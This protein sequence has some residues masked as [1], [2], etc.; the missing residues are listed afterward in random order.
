MYDDDD[1]I[2]GRCRH[3]IHPYGRNGY[4][5]IIMMDLLHEFYIVA[6][7]LAKRF[8]YSM[9]W[10]LLLHVHL[11]GDMR[12]FRLVSYEIIKLFQSMS[13]ISNHVPPPQFIK[14]IDHF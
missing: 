12:W 11:A 3:G 13:P 14:S 4:I 1:N 9:R 5:N 8:L 7:I 6:L 2:G 10:N